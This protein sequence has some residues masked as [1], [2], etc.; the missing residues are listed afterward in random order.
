MNFSGQEGLGRCL[1]LHVLYLQYHHLHLRKG[2]SSSRALVV[3]NC[4]A[5]DCGARW[6]RQGGER[7]GPGVLRVRDRFLGLQRAAAAA[8]HGQAVQVGGWGLGGG[9]G[10]WVAE[11]AGAWLGWSVQW[12]GCAWAACTCESAG[13]GVGAAQFTAIGVAAACACRRECMGRGLQVPVGDGT[14]QAAWAW[15]NG[16]C[17][18]LAACWA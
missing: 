14:C 11:R 2:P 9:S 18:W 13:R 1:Y 4:G 17:N 10:V 3:A 15:G 6:W 16:Y 7:E 12:E 8:A 5:A